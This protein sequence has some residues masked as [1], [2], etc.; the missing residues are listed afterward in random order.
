MFQEIRK[1]GLCNEHCQRFTI[2]T[3]DSVRTD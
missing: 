1:T 2:S 3:V